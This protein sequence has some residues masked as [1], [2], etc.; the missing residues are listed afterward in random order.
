MFD[1]ESLRA[2]SAGSEL[3]AEDDL[4]LVL[5]SISHAA[6]NSGGDLS[7][8]VGMMRMPD[9]ATAKLIQTLFAAETRPGAAISVFK[10]SDATSIDVTLHFDLD[11]IVTDLRRDISSGISKNRRLVDFLGG[12][13]ADVTD[14]IDAAKDNPKLASHFVSTA[15]DHLAWSLRLR[16]QDMLLPVMD[17]G[18]VLSWR[19]RLSTEC[20]A[21]FAASPLIPFATSVVIEVPASIVENDN[22]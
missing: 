16:I 4:R 14:R 3:F 2:T 20:H 7:A 13:S 22:A 11:D 9:R 8:A 21:S 1:N 19:G 15:A 6:S 17:D 5:D 10:S 12:L 18:R